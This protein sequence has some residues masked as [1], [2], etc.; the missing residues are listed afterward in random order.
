MT[1]RIYRRFYSISEEMHSLGLK[2]GSLSV[3]A[4]IEDVTFDSVFKISAAD[5]SLLTDVILKYFVE[6]EE[7]KK[8]AKILTICSELKE[9]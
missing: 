3:Y 5:T 9:L 6:N 4:T 2:E 8:C 1:D 7:Y